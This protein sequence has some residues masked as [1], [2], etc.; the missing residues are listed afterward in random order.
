MHSNQ[1]KLVV[2]IRFHIRHDSRA[3]PHICRFENH[4]QARRC[5]AKWEWMNG[6]GNAI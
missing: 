4:K 3:V 1:S 2:F 5:R 6:D